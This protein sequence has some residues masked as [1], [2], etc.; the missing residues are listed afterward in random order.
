[1]ARTARRGF[2]LLELVVVLAILGLLLTLVVPRYVGTLDQGR[3]A[4]QQANLQRLREAIDAFLADQGRYP[5]RLDEL[6]QRRYLRQLPLD[7]LTGAADW[8]VLPPPPGVPGRVFDVAS[9]HHGGPAVARDG[10]ADDPR[11]GPGDGPGDGLGDGL[12]GG[13]VAPR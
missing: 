9:V 5:D 4:V 7:P 10:P 3:E 8:R 6:V 1:M 13:A 2:T 12:G 11:D